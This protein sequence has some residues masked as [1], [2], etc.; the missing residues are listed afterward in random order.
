MKRLL[1]IAT[2]FVAFSLTSCLSDDDPVQYYLELGT[3]SGETAKNFVINT[4][5]GNVL[6]PQGAVP[7]LSEFVDGKRVQVQYSVISKVASTN[8]YTV[9]VA[10][11]QDLFQKNLLFVDDISRDTLKND[12]VRIMG[13]W[14]GKDFL[15]IEFRFQGSGNKNFPHYIDLAMDSTKQQDKE[16]HV[17]LDLKHN[18]NEDA[19]YQTYR[20]LMSV[21]LK[22]LRVAGQ[23]SVQ[24]WLR[25]N[26][27]MY[28][29]KS[30]IY[31]YN[32][33]E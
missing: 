16:N 32:L 4:D 33:A 25:A 31:R 6:K 15:N 22:E 26:D 9:E 20:V 3:L 19:T 13:A 8:E 5:F 11:L 21:S 10:F 14:M 2:A 30:I 1:F 23:D 28:D 27:Q 12:P 24:I 29:P 7:G 18:A 17:A